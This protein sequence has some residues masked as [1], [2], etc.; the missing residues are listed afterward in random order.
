MVRPAIAARTARVDLA[1]A[2]GPSVRS[3]TSGR[4][5]RNLIALGIVG[6]LLAACADTEP[7]DFPDKRENRPSFPSLLTRKSG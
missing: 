7:M 4:H 5:H 6:L 2:G 1:A 3:P